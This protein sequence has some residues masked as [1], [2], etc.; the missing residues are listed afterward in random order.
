MATRTTP[1][2]IVPAA[3]LLVGLGSVGSAQATELTF[4]IAGLVPFDNIPTAY[5]DNVTSTTMGPFSYGMGN[6]FTP[7]I[8]VD[9]RT[10]NV[11]SIGTGGGTLHNNLDWWNFNYGDLVNVAYP[12]DPVS[13][14]EIS[15]VPE[16]GWAVRIN[17]FDLAGW[18]DVD[19]PNQ[20]LLILDG[21]YNV[22]L[23]LGP[24]LVQGDF[25]GPRH[26]TVTPN[27]TF[28]GIVRIQFGNNWNVGIDNINFDQ[29]PTGV[30]PAVPEPSG[31]ALAGLGALGL[32]GV[33][34]RRRRVG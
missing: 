10:L 24:I 4:N 3:A 25:A 29:V 12:V 1:R 9:Y 19:M 14:G 7:N 33:V 8:T 34:W 32:A 31:L 2:W 20:P 21:A 16:P 15:F 18:P 27:L 23:S 11:G 17:S 30:G 22:L 28:A 6:G 13:A 5:G 26:T